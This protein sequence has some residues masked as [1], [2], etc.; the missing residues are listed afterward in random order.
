MEDNST[1]H[2]E[3]EDGE[4]GGALNKADDNEEEQETTHYSGVLSDNRSGQD[5]IFINCISLTRMLV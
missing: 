5:L 1:I 2:N 4:N 3:D